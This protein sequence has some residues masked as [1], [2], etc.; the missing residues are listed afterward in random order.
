M[1]AKETA[2]YPLLHVFGPIV[3]ADKKPT[4]GN[5]YSVGVEYKANDSWLQIAARTQSQYL[6]LLTGA[7]A[8][9]VSLQGKAAMTNKKDARTLTEENRNLRYPVQ[10]FSSTSVSSSVF[11]KSS[12]VKLLPD[13]RLCVP[14]DIWKEFFETEDLVRVTYVGGRLGSV[15]VPELVRDDKDGIFP[16]TLSPKNTIRSIGLF[17]CTMK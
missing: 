2:H 5:I 9:A 3:M 11:S 8:T 1:T 15:F 16:L 12:S 13:K 4:S 6:R 14:D 17:D 7:L 10:H